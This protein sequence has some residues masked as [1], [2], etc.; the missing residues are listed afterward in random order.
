M[1]LACGVPGPSVAPDSLT[2]STLTSEGRLNS[3]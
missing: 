3:L 2:A 1:P